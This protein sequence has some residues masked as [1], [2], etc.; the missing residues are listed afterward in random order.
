MAIKIILSTVN[1]HQSFRELKL[2]TALHFLNHDII[3]KNDKSAEEFCYTWSSR[4][5]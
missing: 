3:C 5:Y 4:R 1:K 2:L